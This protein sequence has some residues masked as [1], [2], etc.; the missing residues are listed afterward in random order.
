MQKFPRIQCEDVTLNFDGLLGYYTCLCCWCVCF[1]SMRKF[2]EIKLHKQI[3]CVAHCRVRKLPCTIN[4]NQPNTLAHLQQPRMCMLPQF[5]FRAHKSM[6]NKVIPTQIAHNTAIVAIHNPIWTAFFPF[7][8]FNQTYSLREDTLT[9]RRQ[10][11]H[12][13]DQKCR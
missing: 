1:Y 9:C 4:S 2:K 13:Q 5:R 11:Q 12:R 10:A 3:G 6:I 7:I 8:Q